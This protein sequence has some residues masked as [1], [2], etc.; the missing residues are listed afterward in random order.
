MSDLNFLPAGLQKTVGFTFIYII[1]Q[2]HMDLVWADFRRND[3]NWF[4]T[5]DTLV[6]VST[7]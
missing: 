4:H 5:C 6:W 3:M 1:M 7:R 2:Y